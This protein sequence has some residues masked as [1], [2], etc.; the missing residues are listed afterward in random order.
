VINRDQAARSWQGDALTD[1]WM[2]TFADLLTL[3]VTLFV[4]MLSMSQIKSGL[5][6]HSDSTASRMGIQTPSWEGNP[7]SPD[8]ALVP[9]DGIGEVGARIVQLKGGLSRSGLIAGIEVYHDRRGTVLRFEGAPLLATGQ[10]TR[11]G[12]RRL[13]MLANYLVHTG[14]V[15]A[16]TAVASKGENGGWEG[17]ARNASRVADVLM[18]AGATAVQVL[19]VARSMPYPDPLSL[20]LAG[21]VE[22]IFSD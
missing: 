13:G 2:V 5:I 15:V 8:D 10:I 4:L 19:P 12:G 14:R 9:L 3:L 20:G 6:D 11:T 21:G 16:V 22:F 18:D 17:A 7:E 1:T